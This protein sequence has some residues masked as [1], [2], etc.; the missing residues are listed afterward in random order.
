MSHFGGAT[1]L[2]GNWSGEIWGIWNMIS[3]TY[4]ISCYSILMGSSAYFVLTNM[5]RMNEWIWW[6]TVDVGALSTYI[7]LLLLISTCMNCSHPPTPSSKKVDNL[8]SSN[9]YNKLDDKTH[10][11]MIEDALNRFP[12]AK[13]PQVPPLKPLA[14]LPKKRVPDFN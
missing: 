3:V 8:K 5:D 2:S 6:A 11:Q 4:I 10:S 13:P 14:S 9:G 7:T 12:K 1:A